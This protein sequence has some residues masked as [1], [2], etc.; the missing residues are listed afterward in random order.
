MMAIL[1]VKYYLLPCIQYSERIAG[2]V[3]P[4]RNVDHLTLD[5]AFGRTDVFK[6]SFFVRICRL[7]NNLP[8][9]IKQ[10]NTMSIFRKN[11]MALYYDK[12][13]VNFSSF[14]LYFTQCFL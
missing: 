1:M 14:T 12:F 10:S 13:N 5:V 9:S 6:N 3:K 7:W 8:L 4:L 2:G 11:L